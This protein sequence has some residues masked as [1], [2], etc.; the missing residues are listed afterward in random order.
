MGSI[1][2][3][4]DRESYQSLCDS[5]G[6][7]LNLRS[8]HVF[9]NGVPTGVRPEQDTLSYFLGQLSPRETGR[10]TSPKETYL[11]NGKGVSKVGT[12]K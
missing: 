7:P 5:V 3:Y 9:G 10:V 8:T 1:H 4:R 6:L 2:V 12:H 11:E